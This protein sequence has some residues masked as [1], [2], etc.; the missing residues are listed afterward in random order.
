[1]KIT[2]FGANGRSGRNVARI[3][4]D[5]G[6]KVRAALRNIGR[7]DL[8]VDPRATLVELDLSNPD[9]IEQAI[10]SSSAIVNAIKLPSDTVEPEDKLG[11][12]KK[13][14]AVS[15]KTHVQRFIQIGGAGALRTADGTYFH[16]LEAFPEDP[17][18][19]A[20]AHARLREYL[21]NNSLEKDWVYLIPPPIFMPDGQ[22]T[23]KYKFIA[24][25]QDISFEDGYKISYADFSLAVVEEI[26]SPT[27]HK[28]AILVVG[29]N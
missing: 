8:Y 9:S 2:V 7:E 15:N 28:E 13:I 4:L 22:Q 20:V 6:I 27:K 3:A 25:G 26:I 29:D 14:R 5:K 16:Q 23:N 18:K 12:F 19:L 1:M 24:R 21:E 11:L 10:G 17:Y